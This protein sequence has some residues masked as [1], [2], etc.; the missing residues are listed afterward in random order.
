[1]D[2]PIDLQFQTNQNAFS[3]TITPVTIGYLEDIELGLALNTSA[4]VARA[5]AG[6]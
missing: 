2:A 6:M 1:M 3:I 5:T 4:I